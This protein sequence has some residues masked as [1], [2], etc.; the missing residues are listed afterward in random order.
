MGER[1][2]DPEDSKQKKKETMIRKNKPGEKEE[3]RRGETTLAQ[4]DKKT[5]PT[6]QRVFGGSHSLRKGEKV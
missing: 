5:Q 1:N 6:K 3:S 2:R 4:K